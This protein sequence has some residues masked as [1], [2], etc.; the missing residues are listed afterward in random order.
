MFKKKSKPVKK[1]QR[2]LKEVGEAVNDA[3]STVGDAV[4]E[5]SAN[6]LEA[7]GPYIERANDYIHEGTEA[8]KPRLREASQ[9]LQDY[10]DRVR[11]HIEEIA[12][13]VET[14]TRESSADARKAWEGH[15]RDAQARASKSLSDASK[16][17]GSAK[18]PAAVASVAASLTGDKKAVQK[19]Q[20]KLA[21]RAS[22]L[23]K[24]TAPKKSGGFGTFL[25]WV[26]LTGAVGA[27]GYVVW[28][29]LQPVED[30]WSTPLKGNRPADARPVGSEP[31]SST[32]VTEVPV[33]EAEVDQD[34]DADLA[35]GDEGEAVAAEGS[36]DA[37][38]SEL[39]REEFLEDNDSSMFEEIDKP[40][41]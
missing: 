15:S 32:V 27:I 26:L 14:K 4:R 18:V 41:H 20:K 36:T 6:A 9:Y 38:D 21:K 7:S 2:L 39:D 10:A 16:A 1:G 8:V 29:K 28:K 22:E 31:R 37:L 3:V 17:V 35:K 34:E 5:G 25:F 11:P 12:D 23:S 40:K 19:A 13:R 30:P 33:P 24:Q